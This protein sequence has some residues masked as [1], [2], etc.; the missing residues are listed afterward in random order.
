MTAGAGIVHSEMPPEK[1]IR[2]GGLFHGVQLWVNLPA[3]QKWSPAA[4]PGHRREVRHAR[5][6]ARWRRARAGHRGSAGRPL[7]PRRHPDPDHVRACDVDA[8]LAPRDPLASRLQRAGLRP[9]RLRLR[10]R[11]ER[12]ARIRRARGA[13]RRRCAA[14]RGRRTT[15]QPHRRVRRP[16][17]V[18]AGRSASRWCSST[19]HS[20]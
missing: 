9:R 4:L 7:R 1:L 18:A 6:L 16:A 17:A 5:A 2:S 15:G 12:P 10:R 3:A 11:G 13:R 19:G 20:S 8:G 14:D